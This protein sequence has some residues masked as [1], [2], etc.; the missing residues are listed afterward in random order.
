MKKLLIFFLIFYSCTVQPMQIIV[1]DI[2]YSNGMCT[3]SDDNN[4]I[5]APCGFY[6]RG[7][8]IILK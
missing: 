5:I 2:S 8:T 3:Y 7:D 1:T 4:S 6:Y